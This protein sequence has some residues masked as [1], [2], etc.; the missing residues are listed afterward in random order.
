MDYIQIA[1]ETK[2][3]AVEA[4][5]YFLIE[6]GAGGVEI[7]DP[8]DV[9]SQDKTEVIYDLIDESLLNADQEKVFVRAYFSVEINMP[10]KI[11]QI[12]ERLKHVA[13]FLDIGSGEMSFVDMPEEEWANAWKKYYK[14]VKLGKN[15]LIK[16]TWETYEITDEL[17]IEMDPGMAFGTGTHETTAM[18]ATLIEKNLTPS[19]AVLDIG[20]GSGILGILA[21]KLGANRVLGVDID[22]V[23][24]K[25]AKENILQNHVQEVMEVKAGNL[26]EIVKE[27]SDLVVSNIIADVIIILCEQIDLVLTEEGLWIAS[28]IINTRQEDVLACM[29]KNGF[30]VV[31][32]CEENDWVAIVSKRRKR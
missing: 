11:A 7:V 12:K 4:I 18:C 3:E 27:K 9:L 17:V 13:Q 14:P 29:D 6:D 31:E 24:I 19:K 28:G 26:T 15:I 8:K 21:A 16:P 25:V 20:T 23:A 32:I 2:R 22:P 10:E 5:S 30:E 1:I